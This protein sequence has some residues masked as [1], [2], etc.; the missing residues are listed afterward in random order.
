LT[1]PAPGL[2]S[3]KLRIVSLDCGYV[4]IWYGDVRL[5]SLHVQQDKTGSLIYLKPG[6]DKSGRQRFGSYSFTYRLWA[7]ITRQIEDLW[8][9]GQAEALRGGLPCQVEWKPE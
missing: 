2:Q 4:T 3:I 5:F 7:E 1:A 9:K 8:R 6:E